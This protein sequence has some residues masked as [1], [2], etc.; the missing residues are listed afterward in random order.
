MENPKQE[1]QFGNL[2]TIT[3]LGLDNEISFYTDGHYTTRTDDQQ[4]ES[5][6]QFFATRVGDPWLGG[7]DYEMY[8]SDGLPVHY[9]TK[10][11][12]AWIYFGYSFYKIT[13]SVG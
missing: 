1:N 3:G 2:I 13:P 10:V 6:A 9:D 5:T 7:T 8:C 12:A 4:D 11:E